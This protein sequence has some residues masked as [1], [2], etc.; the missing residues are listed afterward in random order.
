MLLKESINENWSSEMKGIWK[1]LLEQA[2]IEVLR[3][4]SS[5]TKTRDTKPLKYKDITK[6]LQE[7][8]P[9]EH[10]DEP[11]TDKRVR[12]ALK[13]IIN[14]ELSKEDKDKSICYTVF[15]RNGEEYKTDFWAP[16]SISDVELKYLIDSVLYSKIFDS[17]TAQDLAGR[18]QQISGK[19]LYRMTS[20][21]AGNLFG[22][23]RLTIDVDVLENIRLIMDA[24]E[25]DAF[26]N[27]NWNVYDVAGTKIGLKR[28]GSHTV[29]P[30]HI[31]LNDGRYFM[32]ARYQ[33]KDKI[34]TFSVDLMSEIAVNNEIR[35]KVKTEDL[36]REFNRARYSLQHPYNM[37]GDPEYFKLRVKREA[38][39]RV[40]DSFSYEIKI[41]SDSITETTVDIKVRASLEGMKRWLLFHYDSAEILDAGDK[42]KELFSEA[43]NTLCEKYVK[44]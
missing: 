36:K 37:G 41:I 30:I 12:N 15:E 44:K 4:H 32:L 23:Q 16:R 8:F 27:F 1:M 28:N 10:R 17:E 40:V 38:L 31:I 9:D 39:S 3:M 34:Y 21:A 20:Y 43:V 24:A 26:I 13:K 7:D 35:D 42:F 18:I 19:N 22:R 29:K 6:Y 5:K 11:I 25:R 14:S 2:I 33:N